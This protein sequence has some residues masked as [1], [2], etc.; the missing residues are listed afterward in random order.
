MPKKKQKRRAY[1]KYIVRAIDLQGYVTDIE[2]RH[3]ELVIHFVPEAPIRGKLPLLARQLESVK[4]AM[5]AQKETMEAEEV[6]IVNPAE[7]QGDDDLMVQ[8]VITV[9]RF[10][11]ADEVL[12]RPR[13][14]K[15]KQKPKKHKRKIPKR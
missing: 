12:V 15:K 9:M 7:D 6:E 10:H 11:V 1:L 13:E 2:D 4:A 14:K 5:A 8:G 3:S